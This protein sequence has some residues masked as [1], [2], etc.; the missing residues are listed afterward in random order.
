MVFSH[1]STP[2]LPS[3]SNNRPSQLP[4]TIHFKST[5]RI[6]HHESIR[7]QTK[8]H[9]KNRFFP[10]LN[11]NP[12]KWSNR[13]FRRIIHHLRVSS[14]RPRN[15]TNIPH[16]CVNAVARY[17]GATQH[18]QFISRHQSSKENSYLSN[19]WSITRLMQKYLGTKS[20]VIKC[21]QGILVLPEQ[22]AGFILCYRTGP[23]N[24]CTI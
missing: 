11:N 17:F 12:R 8:N 19:F 6:W 3:N 9:N 14:S 21:H 15:L 20:E 24:Q 5:T 2:L 10:S 4:N 16:F 18:I 1:A 23:S 13:N 22:H 7:S